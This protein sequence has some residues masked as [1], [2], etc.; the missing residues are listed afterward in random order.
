[1]KS[2][3][4]QKSCERCERS[5]RYILKIFGCDSYYVC[6]LCK[7]KLCRQEDMFKFMFPVEQK[8]VSGIG[9][10]HLRRKK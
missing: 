7:K 8:P 1:M 3:T 5:T 9:R 10:E 6:P 2:I 4:I